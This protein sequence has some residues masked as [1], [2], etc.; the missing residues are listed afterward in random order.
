MEGNTQWETRVYKG[1][2]PVR[3]QAT[4][5]ETFVRLRSYQMKHTFRKRGGCSCNEVSSPFLR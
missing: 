3:Y 2:H 5:H 1:L 4:A